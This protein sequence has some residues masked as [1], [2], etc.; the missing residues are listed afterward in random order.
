MKHPKLFLKHNFWRE[1]RAHCIAYNKICTTIIVNIILLIVCE[2]WS[3]GSNVTSLLLAEVFA[4]VN[5]Q[6]LNIKSC[7]P[8]QK[9]CRGKAEAESIFILLPRHFI[10]R[11]KKCWNS[12][13]AGDLKTILQ[14]IKS[15]TLKTIIKNNTLRKTFIKGPKYWEVS[16]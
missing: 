1:K 12:W 5:T 11:G 10:C 8:R 4:E 7:E 3:K 13:A 9:H 2:I 6:A 15:N 16:L 14:N